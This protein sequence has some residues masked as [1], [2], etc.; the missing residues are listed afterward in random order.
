[1]KPYIPLNYSPDNYLS[2]KIP[3]FGL[4][5]ALM[6]ITLTVVLTA[7]FIGRAI[8]GFGEWL[9]SGMSLVRGLYKALKQLFETVLSNER[10]VSQRRHGRIFV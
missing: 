10:D 3:G 8:V 1:M 5:V 4:I 2:I 7:N 6:L 9:M